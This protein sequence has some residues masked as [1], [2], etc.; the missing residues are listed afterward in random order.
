MLASI[1]VL[2]RRDRLVDTVENVLAGFRERGGIRVRA[3]QEG[4]EEYLDI[5][6]NLTPDA[7][8]D[9][10]RRLAEAIGE[11]I[12]L[13]L[14]PVLLENI[15]R[16][17]YRHLTGD[18]KASILELAERSLRET[19]GAGDARDGRIA[20]KIR[21]YLAD[22]TRLN[23]RGFITFRL[24]DYVDDLEDAVDQAIDDY[25]LEREYTEFVRLLR[26]F[27]E[28]QTPRM[29]KV[30]VT[31]SSEGVFRLF[32]G[33]LRPVDGGNLRE[34]IVDTLDAEVA[35]EDFLVSALISLAPRDI[36]I[37]DEM[38]LGDEESITTVRNVFG[39]RVGICK[40][41][42]FCRVKGRA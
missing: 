14:E 8:S 12:V 5:V 3:R 16:R 9:L 33:D 18:E 23:L 42:P 31:V 17:T 24:K 39:E 36:V 32:D 29:A 15:C 41:C 6:G 19:E 11:H 20:R 26:Y 13:D 40:G 28:A 37:H 25:L 7:A 21:E 4:G 2:D 35:Y 10:R 1:G 34:F 38:G 22:E 27:V 30:H